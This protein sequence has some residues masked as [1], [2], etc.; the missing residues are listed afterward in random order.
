MAAPR[1]E[2]ADLSDM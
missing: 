2:G 1:Y